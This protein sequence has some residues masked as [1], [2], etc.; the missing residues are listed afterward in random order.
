ML[1]WANAP[2]LRRLPV[3]AEIRQ[4]V[5]DTAGTYDVTLIPLDNEFD[6]PIVAAAVFDRTRRWLSI[7]FATRA[8]ALEAAKKALAEGFTLQHT[9]LAL[10]DER[11]LA[12][13][14]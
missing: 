5:A 10:D 14:R 9:C 6:V 8:D 12:T 3:P 1:W 4:L 11:E 13:L 2:R 7:G